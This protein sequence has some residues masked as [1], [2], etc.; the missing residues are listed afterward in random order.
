MVVLLLSLVVSLAACSAPS[1]PSGP[2]SPSAPS[3]PSP[4]APDART[5]VGTLRHHPLSDTK[6]LEAYHGIELSLDVGDES[7]ALGVGPGV[8]GDALKALA[9]RQVALTCVPRGPTAPDPAESYPIDA[10]G[11]AIPRAARCVVLSFAA[12]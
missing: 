12:R 10:D 8:D 7:V 1:G 3:A 11:R 4:T 5:Q 2:P 6:S 9:G